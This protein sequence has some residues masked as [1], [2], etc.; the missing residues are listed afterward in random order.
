[1][2]HY[3]TTIHPLLIYS[4]DRRLP[5]ELLVRLRSYCHSIDV[6][7]DFSRSRG[8]YCRIKLLGVYRLSQ[9]PIIELLLSE[10]L[11]RDS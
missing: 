10:Y 1:M 11:Y 9:R 4:L 2:S 6:S 3:D 5:S 7:T 8:W